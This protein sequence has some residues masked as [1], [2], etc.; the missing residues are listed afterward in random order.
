MV[1]FIFHVEIVFASRCI[2]PPRNLRE[3]DSHGSPCLENCVY[4]FGSGRC[5]WSLGRLR[6]CVTCGYLL[7]W[8]LSKFDFYSLLRV[9][10]V[11]LV[12][13]GVDEIEG[14]IS[15]QTE[16]ALTKSETFFVWYDL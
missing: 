7:L 8:T 5:G 6:E 12:F 1:L 11:I 9:V 13:S 16:G 2:P 3:R 4:R 10:C 14:I 15:K